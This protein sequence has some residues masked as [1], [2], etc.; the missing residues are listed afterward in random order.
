MHPKSFKILNIPFVSFILGTLYKVVVPAFKIHAA[1]IG[2]A[3]FL[4][5]ETLTSPLI[6]AS[7]LIIYIDITIP[8]F[9]ID[10]SYVIFT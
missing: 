8:P 1:I 7:P 5:P 4:E 10:I 3:L 6:F 2:N 9:N